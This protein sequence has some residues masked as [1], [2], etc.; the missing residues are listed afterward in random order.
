MASYDRSVVAQSI[1]EFIDS[2]STT[3]QNNLYKQVMKFAQVSAIAYFREYHEWFADE[4]M[5]LVAEDAQSYFI[6]KFVEIVESGKL[7]NPGWRQNPLAFLNKFAN[8]RF[9][10]FRRAETKRISRQQRMD[11][12]VGT[13]NYTTKERELYPTRQGQEIIESPYGKPEDDFL[14]SEVAFLYHSAVAR[15]PE[16]VRA[17]WTSKVN[18]KVTA[19]ELGAELGLTK[20]RVDEAMRRAKKLLMAD[21]ALR[22]VA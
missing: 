3:T 4:G 1:V 6:V 21:K 19:V 9:I 7:L 12:V 14:A 17:V 5:D 8:S 13:R 10:D 11:P 16:S 15:L 18:S 22:Q 2:P 20:G